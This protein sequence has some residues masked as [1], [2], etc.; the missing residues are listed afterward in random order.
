M[1]SSKSGLLA[2]VP[3]TV[4]AWP[5]KA[6]AHSI[7]RFPGLKGQGRERE[8]GLVSQG[9]GSDSKLSYQDELAHSQMF[10]DTPKALAFLPPS[11]SQRR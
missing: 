9:V 10:N 8:L 2:T 11:N 5:M 4:V 7:S 3:A 6:A 1:Y